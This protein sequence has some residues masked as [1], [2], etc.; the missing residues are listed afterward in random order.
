M[1][2]WGDCL[3][4]VWSIKDVKKSTALASGLKE[5][6]NSKWNA[7]WKKGEKSIKQSVWLTAC[8]GVFCGGVKNSTIA[9]PRPPSLSAPPHTSLATSP[10]ITLSSPPKCLNKLPQTLFFDSIVPP[11][12][13]LVQPLISF[14]SSRCLVFFSDTFC[15]HLRLQNYTPLICMCSLHWQRKSSLTCATL[16]SILTFVPTLI[17]HLQWSSCFLLFVF[18]MLSDMTG[19]TQ[20]QWVEKAVGHCC[21]LVIQN[22]TKR[23]QSGCRKVENIQ[24][25]ATFTAACL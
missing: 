22:K 24:G 15:S 2:Q 23:A 9:L 12:L 13:S 19:W 5:K 4:F 3:R 6:R 7:D 8:Q 25:L 16:N 20:M 14:S 21:T 18:I 1:L 17:I 10:I 11:Q